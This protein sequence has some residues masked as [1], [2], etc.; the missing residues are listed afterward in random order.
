M[1]GLNGS[2]LAAAAGHHR[3]PCNLI[4]DFARAPWDAFANRGASQRALP[5]RE[6]TVGTQP[7]GEEHGVQNSQASQ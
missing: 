5:V 3:L 6:L 2:T 4:T 1:D 7:L